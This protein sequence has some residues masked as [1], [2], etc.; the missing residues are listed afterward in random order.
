MLAAYF[1]LLS[2]RLCFWGATEPFRL[3]VFH[4][5]LIPWCAVIPNLSKKGF[6]PSGRR[7][8][9][10]VSK[11]GHG[12]SKPINCSSAALLPFDSRPFFT[13]HTLDS[14]RR[15]KKKTQLMYT[16]TP[17]LAD[18]WTHTHLCFQRTTCSEHNS[19]T[20][21]ASWLM[22]HVIQ[23]SFRK[24]RTEHIR[25][26]G[27]ILFCPDCLVRDVNANTHTHFSVL[28]S[29][30]IAV[31]KHFGIESVALLVLISIS[32][33]FMNSTLTVPSRASGTPEMWTDQ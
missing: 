5:V 13:W 33:V 23:P 4:R 7:R 2:R 6:F 18:T 11:P 29:A 8:L 12:C 9:S 26:G 10:G 3:S 14:R 1:C 27:F 31:V 16:L 24:E 28:V 25:P 32:S 17:I 20:V 19:A 15:R 22:S 21:M 30:E